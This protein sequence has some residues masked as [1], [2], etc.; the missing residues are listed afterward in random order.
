LPPSANF[1][2]DLHSDAI[3]EFGLALTERKLQLLP[4][5]KKR[6]ALDALTPFKEK[7]IER[8][9]GIG[10]SLNIIRFKL[11]M[12]KGADSAGK[13]DRIRKIL[14]RGFERRSAR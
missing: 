10:L 14:R 1:S 7:S 9:Q 5:E 3:G 13:N 2:S 4:E 8:Y 12:L 6:A 11:L